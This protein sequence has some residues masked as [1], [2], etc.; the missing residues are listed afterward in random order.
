MN[1]QKPL[2]FEKSL[3]A[4]AYVAYHNLIVA[5]SNAPDNPVLCM[6]LMEFLLYQGKS[7]LVCLSI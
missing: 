4:E 5:I 3:D 6:E 2:M 7:F 1:T